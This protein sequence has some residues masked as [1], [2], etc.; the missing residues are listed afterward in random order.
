MCLH[1]L[2]FLVA[3]GIVVLPILNS[4]GKFSCTV[5]DG[6][7]PHH[8]HQC[9]TF[10]INMYKS[11]RHGESE[12]KAPVVHNHAYQKY[13]KD[14]NECHHCCLKSCIYGKHNYRKL[15]S[16]KL[17]HNCHTEEPI[18]PISN[19]ISTCFGNTV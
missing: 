5:V 13:H 4:K 7:P 3:H 15:L 1:S 8:F 11:E 16:S 17:P 18:K 2:A 9:L 10:H 14:Q 6:D 12:W 19:L